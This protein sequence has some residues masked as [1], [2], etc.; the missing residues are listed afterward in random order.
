MIHMRAHTLISGVYALSYII[1][2]FDVVIEVACWNTTYCGGRWLS[3]QF[4]VGL[5]EPKIT[6]KLLGI[7][8]HFYDGNTATEGVSHSSA[9]RRTRHSRSNHHHLVNIIT[10]L[11]AFGY[12]MCPSLQLY[13]KFSLRFAFR[14]TQLNGLLLFNSDLS[15]GDFILFELHKARLFLSFDMGSG[16]RRYQVSPN[17]VN[18]N[19]WHE[20]EM[21]RQVHLW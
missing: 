5:Q 12:L 17:R 7:T 8:N 11:D 20:V 6:E 21:L 19:K 15:S 16:P 1:G 4:N 10:F 9:R 18:D 14:T 13:G 2:F 3:S